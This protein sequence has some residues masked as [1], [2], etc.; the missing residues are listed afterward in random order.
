M[1]TSLCARCGHLHWYHGRDG[2]EPCVG[3]VEGNGHRCTCP[4]Y[5]DPV[6]P[7]LDV[8]PL[9]E[10]S[11]VVLRNPPTDVDAEGVNLA[12][13]LTEALT[14]GMSHDRFVVVCLAGD[15]D[16]TVLSLED[17]IA[18]LQAKT[19]GL[20]VEPIYGPEGTATTISA[21]M[22]RNPPPVRELPAIDFEPGEHA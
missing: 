4:G 18:V 13:A 10:D 11:I 21:P 7:T 3:A 6:D 19:T 5:V 8:I 14:T 12:Q 22:N 1:A 2:R 16:L 20:P 9:P 17:A 15:S